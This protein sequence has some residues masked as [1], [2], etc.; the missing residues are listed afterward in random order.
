MKFNTFGIVEAESKEELYDELCQYGVANNTEVH[1]VWLKE[2]YNESSTFAYII[3]G[4]GETIKLIA[5]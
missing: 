1:Q 3:Q 4:K 5:K 2:L